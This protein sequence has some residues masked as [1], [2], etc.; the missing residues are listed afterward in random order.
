MIGQQAGNLH[1]AL[2]A[3]S[4]TAQL[5]HLSL[6]AG[7]KTAQLHY[8]ALH[9]GP[10]WPSLGRKRPSFT[11]SCCVLGRKRP[12][13]AENGPASLPRAGRWAGNGP[14]L[15]KTAQL[16]CLVLG[17]G[18]E[19]AHR[20][21]KRPCLTASRWV[22]GRKRPSVAENGPAPLPRTGCWA[23]NGP[24]LPKTAQLHCHV[25]GAGP[26][27]AQRCRKRPNFTTSY[28]A[29]GRKRPS[30]AD[31]GPASPPCAA[32]WAGTPQLHHRVPLT[33]LGIAK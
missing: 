13:V 27:T 18:P 32:C 29:L 3:G 22:L 26:E 23:G 5:H 31:N 17:A 33:R 24:A 20:C 4:E 15:P 14:P 11:T 1:L 6:H 9:T 16:D 10:K 28:W 21:R 25:L 30:V 12:N 8:T 2:R 7:P 19:T